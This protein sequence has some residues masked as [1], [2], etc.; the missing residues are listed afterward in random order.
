MIRTATTAPYYTTAV[1]NVL[2][3]VVLNTH[4]TV[5]IT[6]AA[7]QQVGSIPVFK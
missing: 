3:F 2:V 4:S 6:V 5:G 1:H 7:E